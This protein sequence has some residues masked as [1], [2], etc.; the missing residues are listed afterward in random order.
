MYYFATSLPEVCR[1]LVGR[2]FRFG[3][4][5]KRGLHSGDRL[6]LHGKEP[7]CQSA[8]TRIR[9]VA[10]A[11]HLAT[12]R[13]LMQQGGQGQPKRRLLAES[14]PAPI[15]IVPVSTAGW[16][17]SGTNDFAVPKK[18]HPCSGASTVLQHK[19]AFVPPMLARARKCQSSTHGCR[20]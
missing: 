6:S 19:R 18:K 10:D 3:P 12:C 17:V 14:K 20:F 5:E 2:P 11:C 9:S 15:R 16:N 7:P 8:Q 13:N 1:I 4:L